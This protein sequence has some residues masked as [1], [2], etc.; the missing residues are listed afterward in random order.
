MADYFFKE[1]GKY[2]Q[3]TN[4]ETLSLIS[5]GGRRSVDK[6]IKGNWKLVV[7][8]VKKS[9]GFV[10]MEHINTGLLALDYAIKNYD[11][12]SK[13]K[14]STYA[15]KVIKSQVKRTYNREKTIITLPYSVFALFVM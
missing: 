14:F 8:A 15:F 9:I 4:D 7:S 12:N 10:S 13:Y 2:K 5:E 6:I 3:L 1:M 11:M